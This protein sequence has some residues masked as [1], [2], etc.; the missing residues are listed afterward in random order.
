MK[1]SEQ[2]QSPKFSHS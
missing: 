2:I 1:T